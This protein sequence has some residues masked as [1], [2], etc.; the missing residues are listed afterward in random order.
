MNIQ[1]IFPLALMNT[2]YKKIRRRTKHIN[3]DP[4]IDFDIY[5]LMDGKKTVCSPKGRAKQ[6]KVAI[7]IDRR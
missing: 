1:I 7:P 2:L 3:L 5:H 6:K 4:V